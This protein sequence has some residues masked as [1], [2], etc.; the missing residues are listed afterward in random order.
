MKCPKCKQNTFIELDCE[1]HDRR[2]QC[3]LGHKGC[4]FT[5]SIDYVNGWW[6]ALKHKVDSARAGQ[7]QVT[8]LDN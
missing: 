1:S 4:G 3:K 7:P 6:D 8:D 2:G 5:A